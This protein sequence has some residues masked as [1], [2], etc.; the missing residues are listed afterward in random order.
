MT[1]LA[2]GVAVAPM[3]QAAQPHLRLWR[4]D[5]GEI[6]MND[7]SPLSDAGAYNGQARRLTDSCY[8][9][10]HGQD[11]MLWDTGLPT[12]LLGKLIDKAPLSPS[13]KVDLVGQL[14]RIGVRPD[15]ISRLGIS[16]YHFD[17]VGQA[18]TFPKAVLLIGAG[19]WAAL[20]SGEGPGCRPI[21]TG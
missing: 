9:V 1:A 11:Y 15:Q 18:A 21:P 6:Q 16:H 14:T 12:A 17:H 3:A 13:L 4:L 7:A 2:L 8:L 19:D 5:C 10:Q 20:R